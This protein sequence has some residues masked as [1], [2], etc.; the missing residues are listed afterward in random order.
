MKSEKF[1]YKGYKFT[2]IGNT[3]TGNCRTNCLNNIKSLGTN[4]GTFKMQ[5]VV[6]GWRGEISTIHF[7]KI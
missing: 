3:P 6:D 2:V 1:N 4:N 7:K 5:V